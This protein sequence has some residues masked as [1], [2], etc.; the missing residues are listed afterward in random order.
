[1]GFDDDSRIRRNRTAFSDKQLERLESTFQKCQ[2]P[3][4]IQ[5][6][7][8]SKIIDL[9]E[10][11][12]QVWF[13]NRRAKQRKRQ[14]NEKSESPPKFNED[15]NREEEDRNREKMM[16]KDAATIITWTP[17]ASL[18]CVMPDPK[19]CASPFVQYYQIPQF[20]RLENCQKSS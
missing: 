17:G 10:A 1:M 15:E 3:D 20:V 5:R 6:E 14:R 7:K 12:I 9:P 11:R 8:L 4:M 16:R 18:Q 19:I 13:K 2:Y